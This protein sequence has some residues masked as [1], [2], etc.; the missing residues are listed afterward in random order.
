[1]WCNIYTHLSSTLWFI[2]LPLFLH[3]V[4]QPSDTISYCNVPRFHLSI[5]EKA[6]LD[7]IYC[8]HHTQNSILFWHMSIR[9]GPVLVHLIQRKKFSCTKPPTTHVHTIELRTILYTLRISL[10]PFFPVFSFHLCRFI[11]IIESKLYMNS[12]VRLGSILCVAETR[13]GVRLESFSLFFPPSRHK[14]SSFHWIIDWLWA[15]WPMLGYFRLFDRIPFIPNSIIS[16]SSYYP[17]CIAGAIQIHAMIVR[18]EFLAF[19]QAIMLKNYTI[20]SFW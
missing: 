1:M 5:P 2:C 11:C 18:Y 6:H 8:R 17:F 20:C 13:I 14:L 7:R 10:W 16:V 15:I 12:D 3:Q 9:F 4:F 19:H